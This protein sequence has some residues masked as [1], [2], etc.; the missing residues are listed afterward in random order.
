MKAVEKPV[1]LYRPFA[2]LNL[3][4]VA[5]DIKAAKKQVWL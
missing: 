1:T 5:E 4:A 3:G 2:Q